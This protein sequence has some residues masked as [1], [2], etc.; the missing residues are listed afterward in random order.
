MRAEG[1]V[2]KARARLAALQGVH[3][4]AAPEAREDA[5]RRRLPDPHDLLLRAA[6]A[7]AGGTPVAARVRVHA[8]DAVALRREPP[9]RPALRVHR[10]CRA[11]VPRSSRF[12]A[13]AAL[14]TA[15]DRSRDVDLR[16][17]RG[18]LHDERRHPP[19]PRRG[20][21]MSGG[22]GGLGARRAERAAAD[23]EVP[24]PRSLREPADPVRRRA[25]GSRREARSWPPPSSACS[26]RILEPS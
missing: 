22:T 25:D 12:L 10:P 13:Q 8:P 26:R 15:V 18:G 9:G 21:R 4:A 16:E 7:A 23:G 17:R 11:A 5:R 14:S 1:R 3:A 2:F 24:A 19:V 20:V 6:A